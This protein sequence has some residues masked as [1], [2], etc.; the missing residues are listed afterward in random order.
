MARRMRLI[1]EDD[2]L[3]FKAM[4]LNSFSSPLT[5]FEQSGIKRNKILN[6]KKVPDDIKLQLYSNVLNSTLQRQDNS[7]LQSHSQENNKH[8]IPSKPKAETQHDGEEMEKIALNI[9]S[10]IKSLHENDLKLLEDLPPV[11]KSNAIFLLQAMKSTPNLISWDENGVCTFFGKE[12]KSTNLKDILSFFLRNHSMATPSGAGRFFKVA[13]I[14]NVPTSM[15]S[16]RVKGINSKRKQG[17]PLK[18]SSYAGSV[19]RFEPINEDD[20]LPS[21]NLNDAF[22]TF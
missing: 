5:S 6:Q 15:F 18:D 19:P 7:S 9:P 10:G 17:T 11:G 13:E 12:D 16:S 4:Q 8:S 21:P 2:Y 3:K 1:S 20:E 22:F 14:L